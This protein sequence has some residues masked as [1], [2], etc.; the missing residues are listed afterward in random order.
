MAR[1]LLAGL[2]AVALLTGC[3]GAGG[4]S[5]GASPSP[6]SSHTATPSPTPMPT[7][8]P[9]AYAGPTGAPERV[10]WQ[11]STDSFGPLR[12]GMTAADGV[13]DGLVARLPHCDRWGASPDLVAEGVDLV[14]NGQDQLAEIWLGS[15]MHTTTSGVRVG[16]AMEEVAYFHHSDLQFEERGSIG[17]TMQVP[18]VRTGDRELVFYALG[19]ENEIPGPRAPVTG[20]GARAYGGD[21]DRPRC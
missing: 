18:F 11:L 20:I 4:T 16:M 10:N 14:F 2:A 13:A 3:G 12:L 21:I 5:D 1:R 9:T 8:S 6:D 17:G 7:S 15:P 19:D